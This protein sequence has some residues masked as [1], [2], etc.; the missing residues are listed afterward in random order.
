LDFCV[1]DLC[2]LAE[3]FTLDLDFGLDVLDVEY[4]FRRGLLMAEYILTFNFGIF[5]TLTCLTLLNIWILTLIFA[6]MLLLLLMI[7][8]IIYEKLADSLTCLCISILK[9]SLL[10]FY[11][12]LTCVT[13]QVLAATGLQGLL[14]KLVDSNG[15][16]DKINKG[17]NAYLEK[18]RLFFP[19]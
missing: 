14:E 15:L 8:P 11:V 2:D 18:K 13:F 12:T 7:L 9:Q 6:I 1:L 19:R 10:F 3:F 17:L 4:I 5:V 16:L